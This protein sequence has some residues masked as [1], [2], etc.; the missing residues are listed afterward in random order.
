MMYTHVFTGF[1]SA[2]TD[3]PKQPGAI[4][5]I[6]RKKNGRNLFI[7]P[8]LAS[9]AEA[10][11]EIL[12]LGE[13]SPWHLVAIDQPTI[14]P[15]HGGSRPVDKIAASLIS[16][17]KGG[18][19]P[20]NRSKATMFGDDA[21]IW[22]L[23]DAIPYVQAPSDA[24]G[25]SLEFDDLRPDAKV[26]M[27]VFPALSIPGLMPVF[28][29][30]GRGAKYNPANRK[31]FSIDDWKA[32]CGGLGEYGREYE[33]EGLSSWAECLACLDTPGKSDQDMVD[34]ALCA[35]F[36]HHWR[37]RTNSANLVIGDIKTGYMVVAV[38]PD[39]ELVLRNAAKKRGVS[40]GE[41]W[42]G[43]EVP[44]SPHRRI[45]EPLPENPADQP[46]TLNAGATSG[47]T[48]RSARPARENLPIPKG[49]LPSE[50][51]LRE[52]LVEFAKKGQ[53]VTYG[54]TLRHWN[55]PVHQGTVSQLTRLLDELAFEDI[56]E[57]R[58]IIVALV[59]NKKEGMPGAGFFRHA[60]VERDAA[61]TVKRVALAA[62]FEKIFAHYGRS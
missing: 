17:L 16:K 39:T 12:R 27:E 45:D 50:N 58:P 5:S 36:A 10:Q 53:T 51:E 48:R 20:A 38:N 14:V 56:R 1:D 29:E 9:F 15:N 28:Y 41:I 40:V 44:N 22:K 55:M 4:A 35:V 2:W 24:T 60:G 21:P 6:V 42:F 43:N 11:V 33:I 46:K 7:E 59:V 25:C 62:E 19:Q 52:Y 13:L 34:A 18:V 3:N 49:S 54:E 47:P 30:R 32:V 31:I 57:Q 8:F 23:L 26:V 61:I 37:Y